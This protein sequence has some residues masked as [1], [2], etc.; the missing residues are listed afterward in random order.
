MTNKQTER[1]SVVVLVG[2]PASG[3]T[4]AR[5]R[6]VASDDMVRYEY[7]SDDHIDAYAEEVGKTY[8][9]VFKEYSKTAI[10][11]ADAGLKT[12]LEN[13]QSVL[14]DQTNMS[15]KKRKKILDRFPVEYRRECICVLPPYNDTQKEELDRRLKSRPGKDIP[16]FVMKSMLDSFDLPSVN[17][18]FNRVMYFDIYGNMVDRNAAADLFG[19]G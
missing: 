14:W 19:K 2:V 5:E 11:L 7:S 9:E 12:A 15:R 16:D 8:A 4:T 13:K 6:A 1:P 10:Q 18:G 17:E 3:K